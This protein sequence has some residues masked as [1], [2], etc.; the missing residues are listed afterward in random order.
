MFGKYLLLSWGLPF[1]QLILVWKAHILAFNV[2][3]FQCLGLWFLFFFCT[4][5]LRNSFLSQCHRDIPTYWLL[6]F[7]NWCHL[8]FKSLVY[9]DTLNWFCVWFFFESER[10][11]IIP[12]VFQTNFRTSSSSCTNWL[13]LGF[14]L[15]FHWLCGSKLNTNTFSI[16]H[17]AMIILGVSKGTEHMEA[18]VHLY[19]HTHTNTIFFS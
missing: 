19:T 12:S 18:C 2:I 17:E 6:S 4:S 5:S 3:K 7:E 16:L 13:L 11:M 10:L 9:L 15:E 14:L 1:T 8:V